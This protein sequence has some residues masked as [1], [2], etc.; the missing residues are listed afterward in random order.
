MY[1]ALTKGIIAGTGID[2]FSNEPPLDSPLL[3][4]SNVIVTPHM[5]A[6]TD[7]ALGLTSEFIAAKV[8]EV[9]FGS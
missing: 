6:Y 7:Q 3:Q 9:L 2:A 8:L 1:D 5:G 4:L